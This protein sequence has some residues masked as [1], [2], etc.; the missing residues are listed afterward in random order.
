[1]RG[2]VGEDPATAMRDHLIEAAERL[3]AERPATT[4]TTRD[5]ARAAEVSDGVLYNYFTDKNDLLVAALIRRYGR[6]VARF[7][8]D[9]PKPGTGTV[10]GNLRGYAMAA[11]ALVTESLP[12]AGGLI[13]D[14]VLL[15]RFIHDIHQ[16]PFGPQR[17]FHP[18]ADY[19]ANE[20]RLA[21][22]TPDEISAAT[23]ALIGATMISAFAVVMGGRPR[24]ELEHEIVGVV[25]LVIKALDPPR[26]A[27]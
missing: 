1:M 4:I 25:R 23:T 2:R 19:I 7:D 8:A 18:V 27:S 10:E 5:L 20:P 3:L 16:Q 17:L 9:L 13:G 22:L 24:D 26:Q 11:L 21:G 14:P 12:M 15:H 6:L